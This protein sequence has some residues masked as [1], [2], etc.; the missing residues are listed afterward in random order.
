MSAEGHDFDEYLD[1]VYGTQD[2]RGGNHDAYMV[3]HSL[4]R[5]PDQLYSFLH[6][7]QDSYNSPGDSN[8]PGVNN[9]T[10]DTLT[11]AVRFSIDPDVIETAAKEVQELISTPEASDADNFALA[12]MLLYSRSYF[13]VFASDLEG[14]VKSPGYG[15]DNSWTFLCA[16]WVPGS[17]RTRE[18]DVYG[19][20]ALESIMI[21][22]NGLP[23]DTLNP[24]FYSTVYEANILGQ[25]L[26]GLSAVNPFNHY[27]V[28][29]IATGWT[30]TETTSGMDVDITLRSD[31]KWQDG[32]EFNASSVEFNWEFLRDWDS[33]N[34]ADAASHLVDVVVNS[35][36]DCTIQAD[37]GGLGLF[38]DYMGFAAVMPPQIY[39]RA[40][41]DTAAVANYHPEDQ[42]Y[43]S[44]MAPG[45][46]AGPWATQMHT[47]A[48]G[49]GPYILA[50]IDHVGETDEMWANRNYWLTQG[51]V[52]TLMADMFWEVGDYN[53]DGVVNVI[54]LTWV[55][56]AFGTNIG[57]GIPPFDPAADFNSDNWVNI[58]D[59][60]NNQYHLLWQS[61]YVNPPLP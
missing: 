42:T 13:N 54:D 27:D 37:I 24:T 45:Y 35:Q 30:I 47:N 46:A 56:F 59:V 50:S 40:W 5:V 14:V 51:D 12:Y 20:T 2:Y 17:P 11:E 6:T 28:P 31:V 48:F 8:G 3:F 10:I 53:K 61:E 25:S 41:A 39:D 32:Y 21:Y 36:F 55:S 22:I 43:G 57:D 58:A 9:A 1:N 44:D 19:D 49:T 33:I 34:G 16:N 18:A 15:S 23:P 60:A 26:D 52:A 4:G 29:W 38:Y 7:S